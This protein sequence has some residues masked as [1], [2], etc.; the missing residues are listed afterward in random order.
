MTTI[1]H[2]RSHNIEES[3][4][5]LIEQLAQNIQDHRNQHPEFGHYLIEQ[6]TNTSNDIYNALIGALEANKNHSMHIVLNEMKQALG[7]I[8]LKNHT[9]E[10]IDEKPKQTLEVSFRMLQK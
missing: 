1:K 7:Y 6:K 10:D 4:R 8:L 5:N 9:Q 2:I 3:D